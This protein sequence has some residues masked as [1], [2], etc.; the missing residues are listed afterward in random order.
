MFDMDIQ[1]VNETLY[2]FFKAADAFEKFHLRD[3]GQWHKL[4]I[5]REDCNNYR[6]FRR[7]QDD[8]LQ[9][10]MQCD[11]WTQTCANVVVAINREESW[12]YGTFSHSLLKVR[13]FY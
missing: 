4:N 5:D 8:W 2:Q 9:G 12:V 10:V 13:C 3:S 7:R 1:N 11:K 6:V